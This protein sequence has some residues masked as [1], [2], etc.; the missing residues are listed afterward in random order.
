MS[1]FK[2]GDKVRRTTPSDELILGA[3]YTVAR[4][5]EDR[6][7]EFYIEGDNRIFADMFLNWLT[8]R[9]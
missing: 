7:S 2:V 6:P 9:K 3:V 5:D 1:K 8:F 4:I